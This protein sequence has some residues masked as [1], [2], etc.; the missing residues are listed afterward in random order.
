MTTG[1]STRRATRLACDAMTDPLLDQ[2]LAA[3]HANLE[4]ELQFDEHLRPLKIV[5]APD[6]RIVSP[7]MVAMIQAVETTLFLPQADDDSL[8][9]MVTLEPFKEEGPE[10]AL[11]DRWRIYHGEPEDV[12]WAVFSIDAA[13]YLGAVVDGEAFR[14]ANPLAEDEPRLCR[15]MNHEQPEALMRLCKRAGLEIESPVM[16]GL[17][18]YGVDVRARFRVVR[19]ETPERIESAEAAE[20]FLLASNGEAD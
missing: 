5:I 10:G 9:L 15:L 1:E 11:A 6:G 3:L 20:R 2:T 13:K 12:N 8:Q 17:D 18:P 7:V 16:V 4:G 14:V 19:I